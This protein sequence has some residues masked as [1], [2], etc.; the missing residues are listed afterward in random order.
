V[1]RAI[2]RPE[3][4]GRCAVRHVVAGIVASLSRPSPSTETVVELMKS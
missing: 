4:S 1:P 3:P 2:W